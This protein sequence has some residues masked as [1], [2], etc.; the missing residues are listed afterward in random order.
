M[1]GKNT[2]YIFYLLKML[3]FYHFLLIVFSTVF[4]MF[5][6]QFTGPRNMLLEN[7]RE[8]AYLSALKSMHKTQYLISCGLL[9]YFTQR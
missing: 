1:L 8:Q 9:S 6:T 2:R 4:A 3:V 5:T 7:I